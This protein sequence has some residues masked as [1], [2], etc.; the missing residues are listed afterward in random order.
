MKGKKICG[1]GEKQR[2][3]LHQEAYPPIIENTVMLI[4]IRDHFVSAQLHST[5]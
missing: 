4:S 5:I 1:A 3:W 2:K